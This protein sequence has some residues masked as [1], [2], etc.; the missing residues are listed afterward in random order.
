MRGYLAAGNAAAVKALVRQCQ[1]GYA[2]A[3]LRKVWGIR[4]AAEGLE[5]PEHT[6]LDNPLLAVLWARFQECC[7]LFH[8]SGDPCVFTQSLGASALVL[9][10]WLCAR[11]L[12][13]LPRALEHATDQI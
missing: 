10:P 13:T 4:K 3:V 7:R 1:G 5:L 12:H 2:K 11:L 8:A 9:R 6:A